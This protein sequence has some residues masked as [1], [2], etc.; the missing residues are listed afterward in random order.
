MKHMQQLLA[1]LLFSTLLF[2]A[3]KKSDDN[4][5]G[6]SGANF[7]RGKVDGTL[8]NSTLAIDGSLNSGVLGLGG[9]W[10]P[11]GFTFAITNFTGVGTY[12]F[13]PGNMHTAIVTMGLNQADTYTA[14]PV[15]GS[16]SLV[17]TSYANKVVKGTFSFTGRNNANAAKSVTEGEFQVTL[18]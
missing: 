2:T 13:G 1:A 7:M 16:G 5:G 4:T 14:N 17:V 8:Y 3:C 10:N 11:G 18:P 12:N 15:L 9:R 6:G